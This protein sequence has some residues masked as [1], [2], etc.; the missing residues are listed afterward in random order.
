MDQ[1]SLEGRDGGGPPALYIKAPHLSGV[2]RHVTIA[3]TV[4]IIIIATF[5]LKQARFLPMCFLLPSPRDGHPS[6]GRVEPGS[7]RGIRAYKEMTPCKNFT[8]TP[9]IRGYWVNTWGREAEKH[10]WRVEGGEG[11][12]QGHTPRKVVRW[13][14]NSNTVYSSHLLFTLSSWFYLALLKYLVCWL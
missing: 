7:G 10:G 13:A 14:C 11:M 12:Q 1:V 8:C 2:R 6:G 9:L 3:P 4:V 5:T